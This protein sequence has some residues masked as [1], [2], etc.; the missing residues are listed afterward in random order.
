MPEKTDKKQD[1]KATRY[2]KA[3]LDD[4]TEPENPKVKL[5]IS[6]KPFNPEQFTQ[7]FMAIL[8]TYTLSLLETNSREDVFTHFNNAFGMFLNK[9]VPEDE[10]YSLSA[11]H[12]K[13]KKR[14]DS[15]LNKP[16]DKKDTETARFA[17]Y[18]L[19]RDI[20]TQEV[21]LA[22]E[23]ADLILNRRLGLV[24]KPKKNVRE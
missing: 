8:E 3:Y 20:L 14:T 15:I 5:V 9:L 12:K 17:A 19:T 24:P 10:H 4:V 16:E 13:F 18:L 11:S 21:G 6:K 2:I 1:F 7:I 22:P 23:S